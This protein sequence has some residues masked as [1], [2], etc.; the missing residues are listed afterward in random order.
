MTHDYKARI[1]ELDEYV[2]ELK[3]LVPDAVAAFSTL[4][5]SAQTPGT[6]DKKHKELL[7]LAMAVAIHC[8][9]CI[10]YHARGA[11]RAGAERQEVAEALAVAIQMGGG[12]SLNYAADALRAYDQF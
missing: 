5:R 9:G 12:P 2:L 7:A 3:K 11:R 6:L 8:D 1:A 10:A 4:S